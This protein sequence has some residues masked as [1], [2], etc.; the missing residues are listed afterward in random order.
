[1]NY[2][3]K[4]LRKNGV[5]TLEDLVGQTLYFTFPSQGIKAMEVRKVQFTKKQKNG[6]LMPTLFVEYL[7][8]ASLF[9]FLKMKLLNI[10]ILLWNSLQKNNRKR[11]L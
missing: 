6:F 2:D 3:Y 7:K 8:L 5:V 11:L 4:Y 1:M 10:N 9:S